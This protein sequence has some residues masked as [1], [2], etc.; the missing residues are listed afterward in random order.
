MDTVDKSVFDDECRR[1]FAIEPDIEGIMGGELDVRR[2]PDGSIARGGRP[3]ATDAQCTAIGK[4]WRDRHRDEIAR[5][6][7]V[8]PRSN[9]FRERNR[10]HS[11]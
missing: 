4:E 1:L 8:R 2:N 9:W 3:T 11:T 6:R 5:R 7:N 10:V